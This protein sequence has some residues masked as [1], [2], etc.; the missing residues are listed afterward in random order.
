MGVGWGKWVLVKKDRKFKLE[1]RHDSFYARGVLFR[2][3]KNAEEVKNSS[4]VV[5]LPNRPIAW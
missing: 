3:S 5:V 2:H 1:T 4:N